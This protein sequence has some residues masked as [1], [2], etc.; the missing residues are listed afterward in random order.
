[1]KVRM[2]GKET[3]QKAGRKT[4]VRKRKERRSVENEGM[5]V[6]SGEETLREKETR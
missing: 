4:G 6:M 2:Q 1:M 3:K 5:K